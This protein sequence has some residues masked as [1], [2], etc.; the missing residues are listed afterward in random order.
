MYPSSCYWMKDKRVLGASLIWFSTQL[1][2]FCCYGNF[3]CYHFYA[4]SKE[5]SM[6]IVVPPAHTLSFWVS[7]S[8]AN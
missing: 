5:L 2:K 6:L 1:L 3:H 4:S 8:L 7:P